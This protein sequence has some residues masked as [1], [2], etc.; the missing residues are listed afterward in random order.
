[1]TQEIKYIKI[2]DLVLWTENPRDPIS[3]NA[4]NQDVVN[5]ALLNK[6]GTWDIAKLSS[7]MG[8][9]YDF[10]EL[11]TVVYEND[12]PIVYDGN[13]RIILGK[14][15]LGLVESNIKIDSFPMFPLEI[16]CNVCDRTIALKSILRK[17]GD[18]GSWKPL[19]RDYFIDK[20]DLGDKS[21]FLIIDESTGIISENPILNQGF[22]RKEILNPSNLAKL[23]IKIE[24]GT[25]VSQH[26]KAEL[27]AIFDD[28][29]NQ[30]RNKKITTRNSRGKSFEVLSQKTKDII[31]NNRDKD[32]SLA[33]RLTKIEN[34]S[35]SS[36]EAEHK[37]DHSAPQP[38]ARKTK[39]ISE[40]DIP[41]FG[42]DLYLKKGNVN[43][44]YRDILD[45]HRFYKSQKLTKSFSSIL[46]MAL[47]LLCETANSSRKSSDIRP[48]VMKY[49]DEAKK[50]L[51][52]NQK[53]LLA[54]QNVTKDSLTQLLQTGA[55]GY[56][57]SQN[58]EQTLAISIILG[59]MLT[60]SHGKETGEE[61]EDIEEIEEL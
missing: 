41:F 4:S 53:T 2:A 11:P 45:L 30:I 17:H 3:P 13:R 35:E 39:R 24:A 47:R 14:I 43:N 32:Y 46:R 28:I 61:V 33:P 49:F 34:N 19:E 38:I 22:V 31:E 36:S 10:S 55:H 15:Y 60:A 40:P 42:K 50:Q 6:D 16:P 58:Y 51:D 25:L 23:G 8:E 37:D 59:A 18:S 7:N 12:K 27:R 44:L 9:F 21:D 56:R 29:I 57:S 26:S 1:M 54:S 48:Y 52:Q 5:R 20:Y